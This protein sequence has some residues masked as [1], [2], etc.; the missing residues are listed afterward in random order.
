[1]RR[2][3]GCLR[4][5]GLRRNGFVMIAGLLCG[6]VVE[7]EMNEVSKLVDMD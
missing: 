7:V 5:D 6:L 1:M 2:N 3:Q 4:G